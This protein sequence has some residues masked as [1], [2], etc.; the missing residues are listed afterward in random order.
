VDAG[1]RYANRTAVVLGGAGLAALIVGGALLVDASNIK[2][3]DD[4]V[5]TRNAG[6]VTGAVGIVA[7]AI[8]IPL[9]M[10]TRTSVY[11]GE[12]PLRAAGTGPRFTGNGITF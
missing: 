11:A 1:N 4:E 12:T 2:N 10:L 6:Y 7:L 5:H 3:H 9:A 8:G